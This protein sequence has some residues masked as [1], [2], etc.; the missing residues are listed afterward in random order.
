VAVLGALLVLRTWVVA[1][2][3]IPT[4]SMEPTLRGDHPGD[5]IDGDTVLVLK[6]AYWLRPP[7]RWDLVAFA[8]LSE[9]Q[10][11]GS[12]HGLVKRVVGLPGE[13]VEIR[14]GAVLV[15]GAA[16]ELPPQLAGIE[17]RNRGRFGNDPFRLGDGEYFVLGDN[18]EVSEDGRHWGPLPRE[19]IFGRVVAIIRPWAR[20]G[21]V[22]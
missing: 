21:W 2:Y 12:A 10:A 3:R 4:A 14:G 5:G 8:P 17:Y 1:P 13:M 15:D 19:R 9:R 6:S 18:A 16:L 20:A 11:A 7:R 22:K